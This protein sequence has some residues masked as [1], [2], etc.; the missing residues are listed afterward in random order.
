MDLKKAIE[1]RRSI[2]R[3]SDKTPDW[4]KV[5]Q[6]ID[7]ARWAP[8]AGNI[9]NLKFILIDEEDKI[10][11]IKDACQQDFV[12]QAK[13][14]IVVAAETERLTTYYGK[15]KGAFYSRQQ[16]GAAIQNV[17]LSLTSH[18]LASCWVGHF[19][20]DQIRFIAKVPD[21]WD[22]EAI[23]PV[24]CETKITTRT[25][26][27]LETASILNYNEFGYYGRFLHK[28]WRTAADTL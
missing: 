13:F 21:S 7:S 5:I 20:E 28:R 17:L 14:I 24:G 19:V 9:F 15:E 1:K 10:K 4:R 26:D 23:I 12:G 8:M 6:A 18:G 22:I 27:K 25:P 11:K 3:Y 16:V 2:R